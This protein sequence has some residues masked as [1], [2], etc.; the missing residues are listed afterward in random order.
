MHEKDTHLILPP[1][2][3]RTSDTYTAHQSVLLVSL[4][5]S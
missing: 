5:I 1:G 2:F 4:A 3:V